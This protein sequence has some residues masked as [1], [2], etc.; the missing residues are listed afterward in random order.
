MR[1]GHTVSVFEASAR[2]GGRVRTRRDAYGD[3]LYVEEG[4]IDFGDGYPLLR[5]Y[6]EQFALPVMAASPANERPSAD[7][8][9]VSGK[10]YLTEPGKSPDWPYA[11]SAQERQLGLDGVWEKHAR[12]AQ[13][14][15]AE[16]FTARSLNHKTRKLDAVTINEL[17]H[18]Q[19]G[20]D[21][22]LLLLGRRF[23]GQ[24]FDHVS[25]LQDLLWQRFVARSHTWSRLRD[26]NDRLPQAFAARLG[27]RMHYG[28]EL[29][30]LAQD[31]KSVQLGIAHEGTLAQLQV[32]Y[33]VIAI[34]FSVLRHVQLDASFASAKRAVISKLRYESATRVYLHTKSRFWKRAK[35]SGSAN[36]D[37]P[38]GYVFDACEGQPGDAGILCTE[39]LATPSRRATGMAAEERVR[40]SR[41]NL[42]RVFPEIAQEFAAG[43]SVCWDA[44]P[45]ARGAW[46]YY[47]PGEMH[48]MLPHV[49]TPE[50]R[51]H[52]AGEHTASVYLMEGAAQSGVRAAQEINAL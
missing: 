16:P 10:R 39:V 25:A 22:A 33:A 5:Q 18:K 24:D 19:G 28:A 17:V 49:A 9:Y 42:T 34:P 46:A 30:S 13:A 32:D 43:T 35:L 3:G 14:A 47:A 52:F 48:T 50:K 27:A 6:I 45:F 36:T 41:E 4:A 51:V 15:L 38:I 2:P 40:F 1:A 29:R 11:L 7:V 44:E 21:A 31:R 12:A 23:L 8:Y 26:G 20:S 37:L